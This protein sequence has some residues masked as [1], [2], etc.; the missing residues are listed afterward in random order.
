MAGGNAPVENPSTA[1]RTTDS[2]CHASVF[3]IKKEIPG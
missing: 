1:S 3:E 2:M